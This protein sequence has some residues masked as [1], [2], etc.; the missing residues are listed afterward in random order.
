[1][2]AAPVLHTGR[3]GIFTYPWYATMEHDG[4]WRHWEQG[5][6]VPPTDIGAN[7]Y[8]AGGVYSSL[9]PAVLAD[10][11]RQIM[12]TGVDQIITSWW[13]RGDFGDWNL[14]DVVRT[15]K[16]AG[17]DVAIHL[18][19]YRT[20]TPESVRADLEYLRRYDLR[21]IYV[22]DI[23]RVPR[24]ASEWAPVFRAFPTYRFFV[25][26][27]NLDW[28]ISGGLATFA[29]EAGM[30]GVYTY[31]PARYGSPELARTCA[32]ARQ[33]RLLCAP[34]VA[35]GYDAR[36]AKPAD[37]RVVD[38]RG[39]A[40]YDEQWLAALAA[41]ADVVTVTSW[42]EWLEGTQIQPA[43]PYCFPDGYCSPGYEGVYDRRGAAAETAYLNRTAQWAARFRAERPAG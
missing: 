17:L 24:P 39:G 8:P 23:D 20:R 35:T 32:S 7:F 21:D 40:R 28:T 36:R 4:G 22:Y 12:T 11:A 2:A 33:E 6:H 30:D 3:A 37:Q 34:S 19:P 14:P 13:G 31:D 41:G 25:E 29:R 16:A 38:Q 15:A 10:E 26:S 42:N 1:M 27:G 9:D 43:R 5:G 18:E